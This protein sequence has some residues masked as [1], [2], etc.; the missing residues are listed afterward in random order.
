MAEA[1]HP[2]ALHTQPVFLASASLG[3]KRGGK[4]A[5][6]LEDGGGT[7]ETLH[8]EVCQHTA[9]AQSWP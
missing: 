3:G 5:Y 7:S 2:R 4:T 6:V 9:G 1:W 8:T